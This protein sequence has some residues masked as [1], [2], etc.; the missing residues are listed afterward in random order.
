MLLHRQVVRRLQGRRIFGCLPPFVKHCAAMDSGSVRAVLL[1]KGGF[2]MSDVMIATARLTLCYPK[3]TDFGALL[4]ILSDPAVMA[5]AFGGQVMDAGAARHFFEAEL[6]W[7]RSGCKPG[8]LREI[9]TDKVI[10]F[11]GLKACDVLGRDDFELGF[12]L[13]S[14]SWGKGYATEIGLGQLAHGFDTLA[15]ARILGLVSP[16]NAASQQALKK[17]GMVYHSTHATAQR[18]DREVFVKQNPR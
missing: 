15:C 14:T 11:A 12:V 18:G 1:H 9:A 13:A 10:G 5:M 6:D 3:E 17:L 7:T 8:V 4:P 16:R 2:R